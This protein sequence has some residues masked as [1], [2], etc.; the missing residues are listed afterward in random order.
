METRWYEEFRKP[1]LIQR[2]KIRDIS[3]LNKSGIDQVLQ[4]DYMGSAEFE[5]GALPNSLKHIREHL[6]EYDYFL[7]NLPTSVKELFPVVIFCRRDHREQIEK[8]LMDVCYEE[9]PKKI[10]LKEYCDLVAFVNPGKFDDTRYA[11]NF[12]WD[13]ENHWMCWDFQKGFYCDFEKRF[14]IAIKDEKL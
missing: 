10:F 9:N 13:I 3:N 5:F 2:A 11:N 12:W 1:Y 7:Y 14:R 8:F 4:M 6:N